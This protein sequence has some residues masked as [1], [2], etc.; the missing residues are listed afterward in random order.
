MVSRYR[1]SRSCLTSSGALELSALGVLGD[2]KNF[3]HPR[4]R[5]LDRIG[6]SHERS[7]RECKRQSRTADRSIRDRDEW[8]PG[9]SLVRKIRLLALR[10]GGGQARGQEPAA[11]IV[12]RTT[13]RDLGAPSDGC[14]VIEATI[15]LAPLAIEKQSRRRGTIRRN[16]C[17]SQKPVSDLPSPG[18]GSVERPLLVLHR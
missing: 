18:A 6:R 11:E 5:D 4:T 16:G 2:N 9:R 1:V 15:R 7:I 17:V 8:S 12:Q 3:N 10:A 14:E 13:A